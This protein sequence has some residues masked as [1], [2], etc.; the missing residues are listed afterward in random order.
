[1]HISFHDFAGAATVH[2]VGGSVGLVA[3]M[4]IKPRI[5]RFDPLEYNKFK[6]NSVPFVVLGTLLLW[7]C[8][9]GFNCGTITDVAV[10]QNI[11]GL[12]ALNTAISG[13]AGAVTCF[14]ATQISETKV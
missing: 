9:F 6:P 3:T 11:I 14:L 1:M 10:N 13:V 8:W 4:L 7:F 5:G 2:V 12:I